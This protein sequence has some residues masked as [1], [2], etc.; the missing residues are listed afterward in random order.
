MSDESMEPTQEQ[1]SEQA[2]EL[3]AAPD[4]TTVSSKKETWFAV[5]VQPEREDKIRNLLVD[6]I[7]NRGLGPQVRQILI[8]T[9]SMADV[10]AG[11]KKIVQTKTY[12]GY[13][14]VEMDLT[15][16]TWY[17]ITETT[18]ISGFVSANPREPVPLPDE[19]IGRILRSLDEQK[20]KPKPK[21]EFEIGQGVRIKDGP[22]ENYEGQVE[23]IHPEKGVLKVNVFIFGR[24]TPVEL[25]YHQV[26]RT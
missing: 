23:E 25:E 24:S 16:D 26:E 3:P 21:I 22:F 13:L 2:A 6:R 15:D 20:E 9:E 1:T 4:E 8:P 12:P 14:F 10:R 19:E 7:R 18:G 5:K 17:V 11:K